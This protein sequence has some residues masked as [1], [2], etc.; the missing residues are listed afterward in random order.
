KSRS[1]AAPRP[2]ATAIAAAGSAMPATRSGPPM[3]K[4]SAAFPIMAGWPEAR[5]SAA[6]SSTSPR[7]ILRGAAGEALHLSLGGEVGRRPGEG[8]FRQAGCQG[9]LTPRA[10]A[11]TSPPR[12][13]SDPA[14]Q[15][16]PHHGFDIIHAGRRGVE[17][18]NIGELLPARR[19]EAVLAA[20]GDFFQ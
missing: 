4:P 12:E 10:S 6:A 9:P 14:A 3:P 5:S 15:L 13:R 11:S 16:S 19:H 2:T 8:A 20:H 18:G 7:P 1:T 17:A